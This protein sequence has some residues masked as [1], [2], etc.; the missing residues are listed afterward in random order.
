MHVASLFT[1]MKFKVAM[2][3]TG[4]SGAVTRILGKNPQIDSFKV[5]LE[6]QLV[7]VESKLPQQQ[8]LEI[9]QKSGK[10][11]TALAE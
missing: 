5:N 10:A 11:V 6:E 2:T 3:C 4:C 8:V 1:K 9:L 7:T